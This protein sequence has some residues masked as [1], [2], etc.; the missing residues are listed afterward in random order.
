MWS[1]QTCFISL[2][3]HVTTGFGPAPWCLF[4][5]AAIAVFESEDFSLLHVSIGFL[6]K[7]IPLPQ[8]DC[9]FGCWSTYWFLGTIVNELSL[10]FSKRRAV[11]FLVLDISEIAKHQKSGC[12]DR[13][14]ACWCRHQK[15]QSECCVLR[16]I[17]IAC[18]SG[19]SISQGNNVWSV[20]TRRLPNRFS[21]F[22]P[23][24]SFWGIPARYGRAVRRCKFPC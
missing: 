2:I 1:V 20:C 16:E 17:I 4:C 5:R 10:T 8:W 3:L 9:T 7:L 13:L 21:A 14:H 11:R 23:S 12:R 15:L 6:L 19:S 22:F 18:V 24:L